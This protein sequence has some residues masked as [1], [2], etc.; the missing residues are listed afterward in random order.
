MTD[1]VLPLG[2][3]AF[4]YRRHGQGE[5]LL[6]LHGMTGTGADFAHVFD[7]D[8]LG[9]EYELIVP[10]LRGHGRSANPAPTLTH[11]QGAADVVALLDHL[12]LRRVRAIG[13]SFG[14]NILLHLATAAPER[15]EALVTVSSPSY[16]AA[17]ARAIQRA[18]TDEGQSEDEWRRLRALH[19]HGDAQIRALWR[20]IVAFADD[21]DDL[22]FTPPRL[23]AITARML[24]VT[25]DRDPLAPLDIFVEQRRS[26]A[27]SSLWVVPGGGH[28]PIFGAWRTAFVDAARAFLRGDEARAG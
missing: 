6:L 8:A 9:R 10:D 23:A 12:G 15:L 24:I 3:F 28:L 26:I 27:R 4:H 2:D 19:V 20:A 7:L 25:G 5:P 1:H 22:A 18:V 17:P 16:F 11:R 14:G 13:Y 21:V